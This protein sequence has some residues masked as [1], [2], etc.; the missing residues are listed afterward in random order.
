MAIGMISR[1]LIHSDCSLVHREVININFMLFK[2]RADPGADAR[3]ALVMVHFNGWLTWI[4]HSVFKSSCS[5]NVANFPFDNQTCTMWFGSWT[6]SISD[7]DLDLSFPE[8]ID[9][10][11]FTSDYKVRRP[12][13]FRLLPR[14]QNKMSQLLFVL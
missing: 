11:T 13:T 14:K 10:S 5:I 9:L 4:P 3:K 12:V 7:I 6:H 8:G 2:F 1:E